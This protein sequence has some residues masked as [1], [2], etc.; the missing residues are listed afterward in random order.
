MKIITLVKQKS[1][2]ITHLGFQ[3]LNSVPLARRPLAGVHCH[4]QTF[5][6]GHIDRKTDIDV[7]GDGIQSVSRCVNKQ[8]V[9]AN[10]VQHKMNPGEGRSVT[11]Q[12]EVFVFIAIIQRRFFLIDCY[13]ALNEE[14]QEPGGQAVEEMHGR[15]SSGGGPHWIPGIYFVRCL[16]CVVS[17]YIKSCLFVLSHVDGEKQPLKT[18]KCEGFS[19]MLAKSN[20]CAFI[21]NWD[22][23]YGGKSTL[24]ARDGVRLSCQVNEGGSQL[25]FRNARCSD[26]FGT[27]T[28]DH[29]CSVGVRQ[30]CVSSQVAVQLKELGLRT[31]QRLV[32]CINNVG[33]ATALTP[34]FVSL[35]SIATYPE[36]RTRIG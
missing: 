34:K 2:V 13:V 10:R 15:D 12:S 29:L 14:N 17:F 11:G 9:H 21:D 22:L 31:T 19:F 24:Y 32:Q 4:I 3:D 7:S 8:G 6:G 20:G 30:Q 1:T 26:A 18:M 28:D 27:L 33:K 5:V 35:S 25:S 16:F 36:I 23:F